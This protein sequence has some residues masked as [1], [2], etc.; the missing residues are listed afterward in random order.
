MKLTEK[1]VIELKTYGCEVYKDN[2]FEYVVYS[3]NELSI[4]LFFERNW[5][6]RKDYDNS[7]YDDFDLIFNGQLF[8]Y[9]G[10]EKN[11]LKYGVSYE[12]FEY[13]SDNSFNKTIRTQYR[14]MFTDL[15]FILTKNQ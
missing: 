10:T 14:K 4:K 12:G 3:Q 6:T 7:E 13:F 9:E 1:S 11:L 8:Y 2:A 5:F 15:L